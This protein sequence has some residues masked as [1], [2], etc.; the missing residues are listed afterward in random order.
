MD[1]AS[2]TKIRLEEERLTDVFAVC[3]AEGRHTNEAHFQFDHA[4]AAVSLTDNAGDQTN[5]APVFNEHPNC[6]DYPNSITK[7]INAFSQIKLSC[8]LPEVIRIFCKA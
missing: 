2:K 8:P 7:D 3:A 4:C 5:Y 6:F 1:P